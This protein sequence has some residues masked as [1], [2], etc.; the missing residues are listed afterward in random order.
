MSSNSLCLFLK[1][2]TSQLSLWLFNISSIHWANIYYSR[3]YNAPRHYS[4]YCAA[5]A[6]A[7]SLRSCPTLCDPIDGSPL[8]SSVSGILQART[9]EWVAISFSDAWKRKVK[10]KSLSCARPLKNSKYSER[11]SLNSPC[12][13]E[14]R[15]SRR[16]SVVPLPTTFINQGRIASSHTPHPDRLYNKLSC[17]PS[18]LLRA[19]SSSEKSFTLS[20]EAD[21]LPFPSHVKTVYKLSNLTAFLG[22]SFYFSCDVSN[23]CYIKN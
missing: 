22:Y 13:P 7:K 23:V 15:S 8:G 2:A 3:T 17:L 10:V 18:I 6:A 20:R 19:Y 4:M 9:L 12:L 11:L 1:S 16:N 14:D 21:I 5:A